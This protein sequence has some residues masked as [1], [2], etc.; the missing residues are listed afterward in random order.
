MKK[1][2]F[3]ILLLFCIS[4]KIP[5]FASSHIDIEPYF[6]KEL[7]KLKIEN[8][9]KSFQLNSDEYLLK[10]YNKYQAKNYK[11]SMLDCTSSINLKSD[12]FLAY[13]LRCLDE[14][15]LG[16]YE[17][18]RNDCTKAIE[19]KPE[20]F[21]L[22]GLRAINEYKLKDYL[23]GMN[24]CSKAIELKPN[25]D[26]IY[27]LRAL[28]EF[29]LK[30]YKDSLEDC[31]IAL[32]INP[33]C[34]MAYLIRGLNKTEIDD[35]QGAMKDYLKAIKLHKE[36]SSPN[37]KKISHH[38][39]IT[40][41]KTTNNTINKIDN[42]DFGPYMIN[43]QKK[44]K[45]NW[46]PPRK[47]TN[48]KV[49]MLLKINKSGELITSKISNSSGDKEVDDSAIK[50]VDKSKPFTPLPESYK[51][52]SIDILFTFDYNVLFSQNK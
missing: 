1:I 26:I 8:Y 6:N 52:E 38:A 3:S 13:A 19:L 27:S 7:S 41:K 14:F 48:K 30:D 11:G 39:T 35:Y 42:A 32:D 12:N 51:G 25:Q 5:V 21:F 34:Y 33:K 15:Q 16:K 4:F 24:D 20:E 18:S 22:Y 9:T 10:A 31:K 43:L 28:N 17:A 29:K 44:I 50:A 46:L 47:T 36:L 45:Q 49:V 23:S 2:I 37:N 40:G